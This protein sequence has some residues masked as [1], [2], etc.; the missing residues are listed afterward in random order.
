[1][2]VLTNFAF[3]LSEDFMGTAKIIARDAELAELKRCSESDRSEF[4]IVYG[5]RRVGKTFL[6]TRSLITST[7]LHMPVCINFPRPNS[8]GALPG[9]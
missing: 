7:I 1:M 5:R 2:W 3:R 4:V 9:H 8:Y 6:V